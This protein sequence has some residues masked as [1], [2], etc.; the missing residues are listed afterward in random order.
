MAVCA[1]AGDT[2]TARRLRV[3]LPEE[4]VRGDKAVT[5]PGART[6]IFRVPRRAPT[7]S[8]TGELDMQC[9]PGS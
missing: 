9:L 8:L 6:G 1:R 3:T 7:P 2:R 5:K 4:F